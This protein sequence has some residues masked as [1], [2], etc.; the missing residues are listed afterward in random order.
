[1]I[2]QISWTS[3]HWGV[4]YYYY[5]NVYLTWGGTRERAAHATTSPL[6]IVATP[7]PQPLSGVD[8]ASSVSVWC[9]SVFTPF[10]KKISVLF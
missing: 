6:D 4:L 5:I 10:T 8:R 2:G 7:T 9:V 1:M 3:D